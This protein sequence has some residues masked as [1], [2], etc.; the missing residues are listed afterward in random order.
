MPDISPIDAQKALKGAGYPA[1]KD[2]L[3][4]LA[5]QNKADK[6]VVDTIAHLRRDRFDGPNDVEKD[7]FGSGS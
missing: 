4:K 3:V 7:L 6:K 5:K 2:D 1:T